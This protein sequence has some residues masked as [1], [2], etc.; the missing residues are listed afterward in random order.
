MMRIGEIFMAPNDQ[1]KRQPIHFKQSKKIWFAAPTT[2]YLT[3]AN[4]NFPCS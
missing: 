1:V 3:D 4:S 2:C